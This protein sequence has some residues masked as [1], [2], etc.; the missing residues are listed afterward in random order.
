MKFDHV[1]TAAGCAVSCDEVQGHVLGGDAGKQ[2]T[3]QAHTHLCR[4][5]HSQ[6]L[7]GEGMLAVAGTDPPGQC[8]QRAQGT[9]MAVGTGQGQSGQG[10]ALFRGNNM[11]NTLARIVDVE[12]GDAGAARLL[13]HTYDKLPATVHGGVIA[14]SREG[15][16]D[17]IHGAEHLP[18][19]FHPAAFFRHGAQGNAAGAL[20]QE[21]PV[22]V[23]QAGTVSQISDEMVIPDFFEN[24]L[25]HFRS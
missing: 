15:I 4:L 20:M 2:L 8:T 25:W 21:N 16:D 23:Q 6:G 24:S 1:A 13:A 22:D 17:M 5:D 12:Q 3:F 10:N 11:G 19:V 9:G 7:G 14:S 18:R